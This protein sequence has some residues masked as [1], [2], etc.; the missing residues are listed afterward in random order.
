MSG[1]NELL[2]FHVCCYQC[3][4]NGVY[5]VHCFVYVLFGQRRGTVCVDSACEC[6]CVIASGS[7][8]TLTAIYCSYIYMCETSGV[9]IK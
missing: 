1:E 3:V 7:W 9:S 8:T 2:L 4:Y 5:F 6:K